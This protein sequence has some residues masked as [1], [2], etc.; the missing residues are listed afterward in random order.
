MATTNTFVKDPD[1]DLDYEMDWAG[2]APGPWLATGETISTSTWTAPAG[3]TV[4]TGGQAP[5]H[6]TTTTTVWLLGGTV[7][8]TYR[9]VNRITT[10]AGRVDDRS[11]WIKVRQR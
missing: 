7:D 2:G 5:S 9:V 10:S 3:L 1:A 11:I 6:D 8:K 4:G